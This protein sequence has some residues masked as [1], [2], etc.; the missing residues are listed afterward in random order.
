[1]RIV[2]V[3]TTI[4]QGASDRGCNEAVNIEIKGR[5]EIRT[6]KYSSNRDEKSWFVTREAE[7]SNSVATCEALYTSTMAWLQQ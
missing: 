4:E 1:M 6:R 7:L 5:K 3:W 2:C